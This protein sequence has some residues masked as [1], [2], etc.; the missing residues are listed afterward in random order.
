MSNQTRAAVLLAAAALLASCGGSDP[1][2]EA[3]TETETTQAPTKNVEYSSVVE[4]RDAFVEA[5]GECPSWNQSDIILAALESGECDDATVLSIYVD[6]SEAM[7]AAAGL[8]AFDEMMGE[9]SP[10]LVG[11]NWLVNSGQDAD[12][13]TELKKVLGGTVENAY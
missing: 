7:D 1:S 4:L 13:L 9:P 3:P 8:A 2:P 6:R 10:V 12:E 11:P 5:G